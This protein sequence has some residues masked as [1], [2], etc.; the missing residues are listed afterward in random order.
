[1]LKGVKGFWTKAVQYLKDVRFELRKVLWPSRRQTVLFT[2][3]VIVAVLIVACLIWVVDS[4]FG[5]ILGVL[6]R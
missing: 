4:S 1:M 5:L 3:I 2:S 6:V